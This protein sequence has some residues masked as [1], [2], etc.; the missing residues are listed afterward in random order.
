[1]PC[2]KWPSEEKKCASMGPQ[3]RMHLLYN[4]QGQCPPPLPRLFCS[5]PCRALDRI[6]KVPVQKIIISVQLGSQNIFL[7]WHSY[8]TARIETNIYFLWISTLAIL[9]IWIIKFSGPLWDTSHV[10][11]TPRNLCATIF[12]NCI[13]MWYCFATRSQCNCSHV[14]LAMCY[15][16]FSQ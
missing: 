8:S 7:Q 15:F 10:N 16:D 13:F 1:M 11:C 6:L 9:H 2:M 14:L 5:C 3:R 4:F 12:Y